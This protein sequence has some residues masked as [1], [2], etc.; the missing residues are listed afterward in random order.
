MIKFITFILFFSLSFH[1]SAQ[2]KRVKNVPDILIQTKMDENWSQFII[3]KIRT[4][5]LN[6]DLGDFFQLDFK[7]PI[8]TSFK[9]LEGTSNPQLAKILDGLEKLFNLNLDQAQVLVSINGMQYKMDKLSTKMTPISAPGLDL[10]TN[11]DI[12]MKSLEIKSPDVFVDIQIPNKNGEMKSFFS[13]HA[14]D[15]EVTSKESEKIEFN[16]QIRVLR[17]KTNDYN[18]E[19]MNSDFSLMEQKLASTPDL[20][21]TSD[22]IYFEFPEVKLRIGERIII[23][24]PE[25][26]NNYLKKN[27][28]TIREMLVVEFIKILKSGKFHNVLKAGESVQFDREY[29]SNLSLMSM[30]SFDHITSTEKGDLMVEMTSDYCTVTEFEFMGKTCHER[31]YKKDIIRAEN[32]VNLPKSLKSMDDLIH[33][34]D[35]NIVISASEEYLTRILKKTF[36]A[37][38][39]DESFKA[40]PVSLGP[41]KMIVLFNE[42]GNDGSLY[43]DLLYTPG[44]I[45]KFA[46]GLKQVNFAL[47]MKINGKIENVNGVPN[48]IINISD[49]N[50]TDKFFMHG[51]KKLGFTSNIHKARFKKLIIKTLRGELEKQNLIG[52]N[53]LSIEL[54]EIRDLNLDKAHFFSDGN[55]RAVALL[56]LSKDFITGIN[57]DQI[58]PDG[59][60]K[61]PK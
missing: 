36:D 59:T 23:F 25:K 46:T 3:Q 39:W 30:F 7:D 1:A 47:M 56:K 50:M 4:F 35:G 38:F 34:S 28:I 32:E 54:P 55:G 41:K 45:E 40:L 24:S 6:N 19:F 15:I 9:P 33:K 51:D 20:L 22:S 57:L 37:G 53:I 42:K 43:L 48:L 61:E 58:N 49:I 13:F 14:R 10:I 31:D 52:Q 5:F 18:F 12:T 11:T 2:F 16:T 21:N 60:S 17:N 8:K 26:I 44:K 29:W 27:I